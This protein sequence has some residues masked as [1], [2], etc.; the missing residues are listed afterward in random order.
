M[1][2]PDTRLEQLRK[3][4]LDTHSSSSEHRCIVKVR[5]AREPEDVGLARYV[6]EEFYYSE[7]CET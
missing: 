5:G 6:I 7:T 1:Y 2:A 4:N 3:R